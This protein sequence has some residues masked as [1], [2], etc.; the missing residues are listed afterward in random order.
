MFEKLKLDGNVGGESAQNP[1]AKYGLN[2]HHEI[3]ANGIMMGM[4]L[5]LLI[6]IA[7]MEFFTKG[8]L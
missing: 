1:H 4:Q 5:N 8:K 2:H 7:A 3:D 6:G